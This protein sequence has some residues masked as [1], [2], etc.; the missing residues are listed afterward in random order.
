VD[1]DIA[2][3]GWHQHYIYGL[4]GVPDEVVRAVLAALEDERIL[5]NTFGFSF[6][7]F[8]PELPKSLRLHPATE[9]YYSTRETG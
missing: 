4:S 1:E 6:S 8:R 7:G 9:A 5:D 3:A 2:V